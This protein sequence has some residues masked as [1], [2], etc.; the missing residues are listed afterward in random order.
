MVD[1]LQSY[2]LGGCAPTLHLG[3]TLVDPNPGDRPMLRL[4]QART[5]AS[6]GEFCVGYLF[7]TVPFA[8]PVVAAPV[9]GL[10]NAICA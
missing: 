1:R 8:G 5:L 2:G 9:L 7:T 3:P 6:D 4:N 10:D